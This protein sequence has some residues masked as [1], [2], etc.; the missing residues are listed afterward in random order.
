MGIGCSFLIEKINWIVAGACLTFLLPGLP[1]LQAHD[2]KTYQKI[3]LWM[4]AIVIL[5]ALAVE[6]PAAAGAVAI[7]T[8]LFS[9]TDK[10]GDL[11]RGQRELIEI[12]RELVSLNRN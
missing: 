3:I 4:V 6:F 10:L 8:F 2:M 12:N 1:V 7:F 5:I 11:V 9:L